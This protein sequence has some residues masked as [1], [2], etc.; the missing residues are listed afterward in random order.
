VTTAELTAREVPLPA[1]S[2]DLATARRRVGAVGLA[3]LPGLLILYM[4]FNSGGFYPA[5]QGAVVAILA[6][7]VALR[8]AFLRD[9]FA[10]FGRP[11]QIA[12]AALAAFSVWSLISAHW[13][14]AP[15]RALLDFNLANI[16]LFTLILFGSATRSHRRLRWMMAL[17]WA[18][19]L[20]LSV[21]ALATRLRPDK[22]P[23]P[24]NLS[25][26]RLAFPLGYWNALGLFSAIG[27]TL[28]LYFASSTREPRAM[29]VLATAALPI[30]GV[31]LLLTYSRSAII[32]GAVGLIIY[33]LLA[34]PRGLLSA[35]ICAVPTCAF[36]ISETYQAKLISNASTSAAAVQEGRHLTLSILIACAAAGLARI[37]LLELDSRLAKIRMTSSQRHN[38]RIVLAIV[39]GIV[40]FV[41][42]VAFSG[43]I[44]TQWDNFTKQDATL[45]AKDVRS[46]IND[47]RIGSRL[48]GWKIA[49]KE[50]DRHPFNGGGADTF[51]IDYYK[52]RRNGGAAFESHSVYLKAMSELGLVGAIPLVLALVM[53]IVGCFVR[54]RRSSRSMWIALA[55]ITIVWALHA[56]VDWDWEMAAVTLPVFALAAAGL[57]RRG[58]RKRLRPRYEIPLRVAVGLLAVATIVVA[59]RVSISDQHLTKAVAEFNSGNCPAAVS[60]SHSA[61]SALSSRPQSYAIL[62]YCDV[63]SG[64]TAAAVSLM[65]QAVARDPQDW[66]YRYSLAVATAAN[67]QNPFP[68]LHQASFLDPSE[69]IIADAATSFAG[70]SARKWK[71]AGRNAEMLVTTT[72]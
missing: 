30:L 13:S 72:Q 23:I 36:T 45:G 39:C 17:T 71:R 9:P 59:E 16:Y 67:G 41:T 52:N 15:A 8:M 34:R 51:S 50:F 44:S 37:A 24:Q 14:H 1:A 38:S 57:G 10:G 70:H 35:L 12:A 32:V 56:A 22:F 26:E 3:A 61:I 28:G 31:T 25:P 60:D 33:A 27:I 19:M 49:L 43:Q 20:I 62:G 2:F 7:L 66:R 58:A 11:L 40:V 4:G 54:S 29:R 65:N 53:L 68:A 5:A 42:F 21:V 48:L 55:V 64:R 18:S 47:I 69:S 6:G 46:R 63:V